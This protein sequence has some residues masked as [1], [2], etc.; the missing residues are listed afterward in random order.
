MR[1]VKAELEEEIEAIRAKYREI[2]NQ[3]LEENDQKYRRGAEDL[4][5]EEERSVHS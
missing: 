1:E 2:R 3:R 5:L 4:E